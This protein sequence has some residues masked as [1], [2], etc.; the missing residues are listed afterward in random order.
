MNRIIKRVV[1]PLGAAAVVGS[2]GFAY[3]ATNTVSG[4]N[5]GQGTGVVSGYS[6]TDV[7]YPNGTFTSPSGNSYNCL[8]NLPAAHPGDSQTGIECVS[9]KVRPDNAGFAAVDVYDASGNQLGGGGA[10]ECAED[11]TSTV[12]TCG[13]SAGPVGSAIPVTLIRKVDIE[14]IQTS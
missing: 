3:M 5:A 9:F 13:V 14:A 2:A 12:W 7:H 6:V 8:Q 4:S 11:A 10:T 1:L